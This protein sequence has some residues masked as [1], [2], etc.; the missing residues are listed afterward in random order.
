MLERVTTQG[1]PHSLTHSY[2][3]TY[4]LTHSLS[5]SRDLHSGCYALS[6]SFILQSLLFQESVGSLSGATCCWTYQESRASSCPGTA[7]GTCLKICCITRTSEHQ[8]HQVSEDVL[9]EP[10]ATHIQSK[11]LCITPKNRTWVLKDDNWVTDF[12]LTSLDMLEQYALPKALSGFPDS[13]AL[14]LLGCCPFRCGCW[15]VALF[16]RRQIPSRLDLRVGTLSGYYP[17]ILQI[18]F[19][20]IGYHHL[21]ISIYQLSTLLIFFFQRLF[22]I[23]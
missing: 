5:V 1:C 11:P 17:W 2:R 21:T 3:Y 6:S 14:R 12:P 20:I 13:E 9:C 10:P 8:E 4:L 16:P 23:Y 18:I 7:S 19:L 22:G 15:L